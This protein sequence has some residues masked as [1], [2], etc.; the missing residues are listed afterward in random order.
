MSISRVSMLTRDN[1]KLSCRRESA[2]RFMSLNILVIHS[3]SFEMTMLSRACVSPYWYSV[4]V[5]FVR[6]SASKNGVALKPGVGVV[7]G[8]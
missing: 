8:H 3:R 7:Q 1:K 2:R 4:L 6:C 5:P